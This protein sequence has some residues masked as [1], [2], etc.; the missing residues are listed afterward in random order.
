MT[1]NKIFLHW[2]FIVQYE[3]RVQKWLDKFAI[4]NTPM[5]KIRTLMLPIEFLPGS[6]CDRL[7]WFCTNSGMYVCELAQEILDVEW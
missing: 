4:E 7:V 6:W 5:E 2:N 3:T 1:K